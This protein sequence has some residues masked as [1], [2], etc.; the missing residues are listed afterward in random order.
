MNEESNKHT[1]YKTGKWAVPEEIRKLKPV[2]TM[3]KKFNNRYYVYERTTYKD[4]KGNHHSI[5]GCEI[6]YITAEEG[7]IPR[8]FPLKDLIENKAD[9]DSNFTD[10]V[11]KFLRNSVNRLVLLAYGKNCQSMFSSSPKAP[12]VED[13][14]QYL[15]PE[16]KENFPTSAIHI[17]QHPYATSRK[18]FIPS[19]IKLGGI[20]ISNPL[21][22]IFPINDFDFNA[23]VDAGQSQ[24]DNAR[25]TIL[26]K[27]SSYYMEFNKACKKYQNFLKRKTGN[28]LDQE[29]TTLAKDIISKANSYL[30]QIFKPF[31]VYIDVKES[32]DDYLNDKRTL[33]GGLHTQIH[34]LD[35][36]KAP[37]EEPTYKINPKTSIETSI[38]Q[39]YLSSLTQ[40]FTKMAKPDFD[41]FVLLNDTIGRIYI[42]KDAC[43][44]NWN[45]ITLDDRIKILKYFKS[46]LTR[47]DL[48][49]IDYDDI[50]MRLLCPKI[51]ELDYY[52]KKIKQIAA[53]L[54][55]P[56]DSD[57]DKIST[58]KEKMVRSLKNALAALED[59]DNEFIETKVPFSGIDKSLMA[60][61]QSDES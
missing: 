56:I 5:I 11:G 1:K 26:K 46:F 3:V 27:I 29:G 48:C 36:T 52:I 59:Y 30:G 41:F 42:E 33:E 39:S 49:G 34:L 31:N 24:Y 12:T 35:F 38:Y 55:S 20:P 32:V 19:L 53:G 54:E 37:S 7:Y 23:A 47:W 25:E 40:T 50:E 57:P 6:G 10:S 44:Y 2:G 61:L 21:H 13:V 8:E 60:I 22:F 43:D 9:K 51:S 14:I 4:N 16:G 18:C 15:N 17:S 45:D 28:K 58:H